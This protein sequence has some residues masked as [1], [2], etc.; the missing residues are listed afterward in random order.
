MHLL[1]LPDAFTETVQAMSAFI[2]IIIAIYFWAAYKKYM[3][4]MHRNELLDHFLND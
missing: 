3:A 1:Q 2:A 4:Q